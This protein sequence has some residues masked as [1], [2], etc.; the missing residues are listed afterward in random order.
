VRPATRWSLFVVFMAVLMV[1]SMPASA[2][3]ATRPHTRNMVALGH[4]PHP[5]TFFGEP[6]GVRHINS[7]L[8]FRGNT[9]FQGNYNGFR[10]I[11]ITDSANPQ[12]I[13]HSMCNGDQGDLVVSGDILVRSWNS[14]K[15]TTRECDGKKVPAGWEGVHVYD[16]SDLTDPDMVAAVELPCG[17]HTVTVAGVSGGNL[18]VYS[19][20]SSSSG[21]VDGTR[22]NDDPVG[23]FMDV[24]SIP[25]AA[26][27]NAILL[28]REELAGP[29][30]DVRTGC[31]DA[32]VILGQVNKAVCASADTINVWDIGA[33]ATPGG[34]LEDPELLFTIFEPGVGTAGTNGRWH[35]GTFTW[36]GEVLITGWEP[37]GGAEP[38]CESTDPP[39][40]KSMFFYDADTGAKLGTWVL[41]RPQDG[42]GE[43]CTIHN[44]NIVPFKRG[45]RYIAVSGNYQAGTWV[46]DFTNPAAPTTVAWSDPPALSPPDLGGAWST[47]WYNNRLYESEITVGLNLFRVNSAKLD[48]AVQLPFLNP[49]T[50]PFST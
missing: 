19:N 29:T 36:D 46:T 28:R 8:A 43:N 42:A 26:P 31:H 38:E 45:N 11:D 1:A 7:D 25:V 15:T 22:P 13:L 24:I 3:H 5:A 34:T 49:Q 17:S 50:Q 32:G 14:P 16:I 41:P 9:A 2:N 44:Y 18:I 48:G 10:I 20:N 33:N 35:S 40:D 27:Q 4:A 30:T 37:G 39:E 6:D 12:L 47:Y 23:D 21:C